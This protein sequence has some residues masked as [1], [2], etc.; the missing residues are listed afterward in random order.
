M[1]DTYKEARDVLSGFITTTWN[2]ATSSAPLLYDNQDGDRPEEPT[3][4]GRLTI[5]HANGTRADLA[6]L[7]FRREGLMTVQVFV[8]QGSGTELA[9]Q[10]AEALVEALEGVGPATLENVWLRDIGMREVGPDG[11]YHQVNVEAEFTFDRL[12]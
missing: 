1:A 8:P 4:F 10:T 11:T 7:R 6:G 3:L 2:T 5:Q 9:D 12:A